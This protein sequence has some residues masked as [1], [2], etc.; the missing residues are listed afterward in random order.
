MDAPPPDRLEALRRVAG[1]LPGGMALGRRLRRLLDPALREI[2]RLEASTGADV[3]QPF[4]DTFDDRYPTL[5]DAIATRLE[6]I[7]APRILSFGCSSG[8]EV[9]ALRRRL[10]GAKLMG[11]DPNRRALAQA[12]AADPAGDY[13][14]ATAPPPGK[15]FDAILA[16]AVLRHGRLEAD[17]PATCTAILPFSR[18][19]AALDRLD[20]A[21]E[22]GGWLA[23]GNA[24]F[25][26]ADWHGAARY[27]ADETLFEHLSWPRLLYG[28]DD[29]R[30]ESGDAVPVLYRKLADRP[31]PQSGRD[32]T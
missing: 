22:P 9:R 18:F 26:L 12:R 30:L 6:R 2:A 28:A 15:R 29:R 3:L 19:A 24:H 21:L 13:R 7:P 8:A 27:A 23:L 5:F 11:I 16:M 32:Q 20:A 17:R 4:P 1:R 31:Q 14:E 10:P 25:R